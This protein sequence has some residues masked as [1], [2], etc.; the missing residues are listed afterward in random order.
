[1]GTN[2]RKIL[3]CSV[4][5]TDDIQAL[6]AKA[7]ELIAINEDLVCAVNPNKDEKAQHSHLSVRQNNY[8]Q[9]APHNRGGRSGRGGI[10]WQGPQPNQGWQGNRH[11][12]AWQNPNWQNPN[13]QNLHPPNTQR[14]RPGG[15]GRVNANGPNIHQGPRQ[16]TPPAKMP[17]QANQKPLNWTNY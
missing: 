6:C 13:W 9:R 7:D 1:M 17:T 3:K 5:K 16:T 4:G 8:Q 10:G 14:F 15:G 12:T 11:S 2:D